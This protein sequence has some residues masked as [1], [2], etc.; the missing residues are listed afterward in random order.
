[1]NS[2]HSNDILISLY[3]KGYSHT[4]R[5][6]SLMSLQPNELSAAPNLLRPHRQA[7]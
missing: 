1:M 4:A 3:E 6:L 5:G 7:Y 2:H